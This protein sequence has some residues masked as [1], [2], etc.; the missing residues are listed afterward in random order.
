VDRLSL[1]RRGLEVQLQTKLKYAWV[2]G[3]GDGAEARGA[4]NDVWGAERRRVRQVEDFG[5]EFEIEILAEKDSLDECS[6]QTL[7]ELFTPLLFVA[8]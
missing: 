5:A 8:A 3:G 7:Y 1:Q 6:L 4:G 2:A